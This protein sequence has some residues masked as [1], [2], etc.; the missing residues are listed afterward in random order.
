MSHGAV[1][2]DSLP[3]ESQ[4]SQWAF[5]EQRFLVCVFGEGGKEEVSH[6]LLSVSGRLPLHAKSW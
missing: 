1:L 5:L 4:F 3:P 6:R 2:F